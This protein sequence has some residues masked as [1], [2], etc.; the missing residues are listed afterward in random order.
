MTG[1]LKTRD[2]QA[3]LLYLAIGLAAHVIGRRYTMGTADDMG[4]G[5]FPFLVSLLLMGIGLASILRGVIRGGAPAEV[6][7]WRAMALFTG[8]IMAFG[9]ATPALGAVITLPT[10]TL[11]TMAASKSF[12][13]NR[14]TLLF[15]VALTTVCI[16]VFVKGLGLSI[17]VTGWLFGG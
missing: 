10:L 11:V 5:Y 8:A 6:P 3:G 9:F 7:R 4:S 14:N 17:P 12:A 1:V 2:V 13:V 16:L 15:V